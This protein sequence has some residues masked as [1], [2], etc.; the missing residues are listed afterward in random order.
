MKTGILTY[1]NTRNC[2]AL[3]QAY[4]LQK[5]LFD[6]GID[7]DIIDYCCP[8]IDETYKLKK[9][10]EIKN[11]KEFIK[12]TLTINS[13]K[14]SQKKFDEFKRQYL[15]LSEIYSSDTIIKA[16][17]LYDAFITGSDQVWNFNL[18]GN[19]YTYLLNF[20]SDDKIKLSYAASM[21]S[22]NIGKENEKI[23][24]KAL[25]QFSSI[26]VREKNLKEYVDRILEIDSKLVLDPTLLLEKEEYNF[27][28]S[29]KII[30]PKYIFV[31]T[32]ASTPNI[33]KAAKALSQKTGYP[34][35]WGHM[36]YRKK[37]GVINKTDISPD[38][39]VNYIKN[40][41]YVLTSSFHGMA[42]SIVMEKQ[43]F[44][45]LDT[46]K[47]NNNS[48]LETLAEILGL[49]ERNMGINAVD[50]KQ[51][52]NYLKIKELLKIKRKESIDFL[53]KMSLEKPGEY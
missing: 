10:N 42:L 31:Y 52:I 50:F 27:S 5:T 8:K 20:A 1:H 22:E 37:K 45:D 51:D 15:K 29:T 26:S 19:D 17:N 21:G 41:E 9:L 2:G 47:Q 7:N 44:Y 24:A 13:A 23:F 43:F 48:R 3:L 12:W 46:K 39:F 40:A 35:I 33:E 6:M 28:E 53:A 18:N 4:A 11:I 16:N 25:S 36:S 32:I 14:K 30:N 34:I 49:Q 38:E